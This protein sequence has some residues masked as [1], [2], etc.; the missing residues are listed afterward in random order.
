[1]L[2]IDPEKSI[3]ISAISIDIS[4]DIDRISSMPKSADI[5]ELLNCTSI[6]MH[7]GDNFLNIVNL[8]IIC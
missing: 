4:I 5:S 1:M 8:P 6:G 7:M 2:L 3:E